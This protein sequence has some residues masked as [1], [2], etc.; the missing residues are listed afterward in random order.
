VSQNLFKSSQNLF[1]LQPEAVFSEFDHFID[2]AAFKEALGM[3][4]LESYHA[5]VE[6]AGSTANAA[7]SW[8]VLG[9]T[10]MQL[11]LLRGHPDGHLDIDPYKNLV[12]DAVQDVAT[13]I[14]LGIS[15]EA[16]AAKATRL[17]H[18]LNVWHNLNFRFETFNWPLLS[19][20]ECDKL[21]SLVTQGDYSSLT[22]SIE[23]QA[24]LAYQ[25]QI[26]GHRSH[27]SHPNAQA[28]LAYLQVQSINIAYYVLSYLGLLAADAESALG[29]ELPFQHT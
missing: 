19:R 10:K 4:V 8:L 11:A 7:G 6:A 18:F 17:L 9:L 15:D 24:Y 3:S 26:V 1:C 23:G 16:T 5:D 14:S 20:E 2:A 21:L 13:A 25:Y 22:E 27:T 29:R 12:A 28:I